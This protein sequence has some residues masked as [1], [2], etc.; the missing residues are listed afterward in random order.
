MAIS[1]NGISFFSPVVN[2]ATHENGENEGKKELKIIWN[3]YSDNSM[4]RRKCITMLSFI[5]KRYMNFKMFLEDEK[6]FG[7]LPGKILSLL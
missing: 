3:Y 6:C 4:K 7:I 2:M 5:A 1:C